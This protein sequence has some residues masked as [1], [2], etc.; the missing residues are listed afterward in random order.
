MIL[1]C[2]KFAT[3]PLHPRLEMQLE[4]LDKKNIP[5]Y[6]LYSTDKPNLFWQ[7]LNLLTLKYFRI[8]LILKSIFQFKNNKI[9][10]IYDFALLPIACF[11]KLCGK[12]VI[13]ETL[14]DNVHLSFDGLEKKMK[15]I[16][17]LK[18]VILFFFSSI[19]KIISRLFCDYIIVNSDN[20]LALFPSGKTTLIYYASPFEGFTIP[21]FNTNNK[22]MFLYV[23]KLTIDKGAEIYKTLSEKFNTPVLF[24]GVTKDTYSDKLIKQEPQ[25]FIYKGFLNSADLLSM[26]KA[27]S[28]KYNLVGL[29][30]I[31][32]VHKSYIYQEANKDID[33]MCIGMP[34]IGN[35][36]PPTKKKIDGGA[37]CF[38]DNEN[39]ISKLITN[40]NGYFDTVSKKGQE[41]Y[42]TTFSRKVFEL[43][44]TNILK[45]FISL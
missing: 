2:T 27:E 19:E 37:G 38:F 42:A 40:E 20:L 10:H 7:I 43:K 4:I 9:I 30:I 12:K 31:Q 14:D 18:P 1:F 24:F 25:L 26:L 45:L 33:Y 11:A 8:D 6:V 3:T 16:K 41:L 5:Y 13:Y 28:E 36:R 32:P 22:T 15:P 29:S 44:Y 34:F 17:L 23:G 35:Y 39:C 21:P